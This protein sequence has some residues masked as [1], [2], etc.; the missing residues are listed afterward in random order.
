M[1]DAAA[2]A[3][4]AGAFAGAVGP[5]VTQA[6]SRLHQLFRR[7]AALRR[8]LD[9]GAGEIPAAA[10]EDMGSQLGELLGPAVVARIVADGA[11]RHDRYLDAIERRI[12]RVCANPGKDL[13]KLE[14]LSP[15]WQRFLASAPAITA[16]DA[17]GELRALLE[18]Y[19]ISLFAPEL[20]TARKVSA[21]QLEQELDELTN[22]G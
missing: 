8:R 3:R 12:E 4:L 10:I 22:G 19:R 5:A 17:L 11:P 7:G 9:A 14:Q 13:K 2:Y 15:L 16:E 18:E 6:A 21:G 20:G 1:R